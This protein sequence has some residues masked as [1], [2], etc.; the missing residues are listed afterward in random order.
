MII[1]TVQY[2]SPEQVRRL[3]VDSRT[4]IWSLGVVCYEMDGR[5]V[6][7]QGGDGWRHHCFNPASEAFFQMAFRRGATGSRVDLKKAL[8]K[9]RD[10]RYQTARELLIDLKRLSRELELGVQLA[11]IGLTASDGAWQRERCPGDR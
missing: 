6:A 10:E 5:R 3:D 2:M 7:L 1:G 11:G 8:A 9:E 4:D